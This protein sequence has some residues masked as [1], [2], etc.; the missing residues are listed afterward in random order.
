TKRKLIRKKPPIVTDDNFVFCAR[1]RMAAP[2]IGCGLSYAFDIA[3]R[4]LF[5]DHRSP[6]IRAKLDF[7]HACQGGRA[8]AR[9]ACFSAS[10][11]ACRDLNSGPVEDCSVAA[12]K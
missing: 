6:T 10:N 11:R 2:V 9:H 7:S 12:V 3:E 5:R 8:L 4:E 1:N